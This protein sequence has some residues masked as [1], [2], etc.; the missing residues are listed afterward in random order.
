MTTAGKAGSSTASSPVA[1]A[2]LAE[3]LGK[4][5]P[6][7]PRYATDAVELVL[8][9]A[10]QALASDVHFH[11]G[12]VGLEVRWRLDG[13]LHPVAILPA[14]LAPNVV[15]RLKVLAEL[16]SY[17]TDVPQEGRIRAAP[18]EVEM[19]ISTFPT[20]HG[21]RAV[22]RV[23]ATPGSFL[24]LE[25]LGLPGEIREALSGLLDETSGAVVLSGPAG[26]GKTTTIYACLRE[27]AARTKGERSLATIE[28][29][30]ESAV[31]GVSQAQVNPTAGLTL[32]TGLKSLLRQDPEVLA[33]GEIRDRATAE[34]AF[35]AA[36]T[37]HLTL[38]TFHAGSAGE[39]VGRLLDMGLEPY[40]IRSGLLAVLSLRLARRLCPICSVPA[41]AREQHLG[42]PVN[43]AHVPVGCD[44][45]GRTGYQGRI[46]LAELLLPRLG[47]IGP[48]I[49]AKADVHEIERLAREAGMVTRWQRAYE[50]VE[51]GATSPAEIRRVLGVSTQPA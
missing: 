34:L 5:D 38:T 29:P 10:S 21:E 17:R 44:S 48:A 2:A 16:L 14:K 35:Q 3:R 19:R 47:A 15:A 13:V 26:S 31:P 50:A 39:V 36:L 51:S 8:S 22:V 18:G 11:P 25:D 4:L 42:L 12:Q 23:F 41:G 7:S 46:I 9:H 32:E 20:L 33:I 40:A 43:Q 37:G 6:T 45:C 27:L 28:D 49:L 30:I 1:A 24:R